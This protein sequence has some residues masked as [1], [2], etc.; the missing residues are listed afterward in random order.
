MTRG[1]EDVL[2]KLSALADLPLSNGANEICFSCS[3]KALYTSD[4]PAKTTKNTSV[5][6]ESV[7]LVEKLSK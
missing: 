3:R 4:T 6:C 5:W 1:T 2:V 7:A